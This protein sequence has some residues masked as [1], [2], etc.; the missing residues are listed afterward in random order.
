MAGH[1]NKTITLLAEKEISN[2]RKEDIVFLSDPGVDGR[3]V[4]KLI[5]ERLDGG[6][7]WIDRT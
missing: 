4:L 6:M 3:I 7:D 1:R 5:C 2:L